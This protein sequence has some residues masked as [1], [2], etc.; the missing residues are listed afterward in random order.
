MK[1]WLLEY[2]IIPRKERL[3]IMALLGILAM[4]WLVPFLW[5]AAH[6]SDAAFYATK[7]NSVSTGSA[8]TVVNLHQFDPNTIDDNEWLSLG[9]PEH[10]VHMIRNYLNKGGRFRKP[11]ALMSI[12]GIDTSIAK[13]LIPYVDIKGGSKA[14]YAKPNINLDVSTIDPRFRKPAETRLTILDINSA[15]SAELETLPWIGA[16]TASRIIKYREAC[17]G[18]YTVDQ[19]AGIYGISDTAFLHFRPYLKIGKKQLR[20]LKVNEDS[21]QTLSKHPYM[22]FRQAKALIAYRNE[23]GPFKNKQ[24]LLA[25]PM[26]DQAWLD[27]I[28]PYLRF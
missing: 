28:E 12:Y 7:A 2:F 3:G 24:D 17:G 27:K 23:H 4:V 21:L 9:V 11:E 25:I 19:L 18:F 10:T 22:Q 1:E 15:D 8:K 5:K 20:L 16:K 6:K 26:F 13:K 14:S